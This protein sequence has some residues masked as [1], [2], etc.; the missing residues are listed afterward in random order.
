MSDALI[1][2]EVAYATSGEQII[3]ALKLPEGA[4][5]EEAIKASGLRACFPEI[6]QAQL[7]A[8]IFGRVCTLDQRLKQADRVEIYRP[9]KHDPKE[10]RRQ[11]AG[12]K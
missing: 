10:A 1:E 9:L 3:V 2:V 11:R 12:K 7:Q 4:T 6:D 5:V 8:G